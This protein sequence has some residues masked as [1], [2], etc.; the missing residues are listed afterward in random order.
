[1]DNIRNL[2]QGTDFTFDASAKQITF[3][4]FTPVHANILVI[5]NVTDNILIYTSTLPATKGSLSGQVL[6]MDYDTTGMDDADK[7]QLRYY[8]PAYV[9]PVS[10]STLATQ[11][12][13]AALLAKVIAAPSTEAKQ[14]IIITALAS[15]LTELQL[16]ADLTET[17]PVSVQSLPSGLA[18]SANQA[19]EILELTNIISLL[20]GTLAVNTGLSQPLTDAQLRAAAV[21]VTANAGTNLNTSALALEATLQSV[22]TAVEILDN[23]ISANRGLV[24]EDNSAAILAKLSA[25]PSTG[26]KQDT[27]NTALAAIQTAVQIL[28]NAISGS[29]MQ[30]DVLTLPALPA[31]TNNIGD[32]D[33]L[34]LPALPAGTNNIGDVDVLTLPALPAGTNNIG[35]VDVLTLPA[36]PTGSNVIGKINHAAAVGDGATPYKLT[37]AASTNAT[38]VKGS[39]AKLYGIQVY[40]NN[41]AVRYLKI[42]NKASAPTVGTD[43]PIKVIHIPGNT[44]GAGSN[45]PIPSVGISLATGLAFAITT[46]IADSDTGAVALN[47]ITVNL[48]YI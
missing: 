27:A 19:T 5:S 37:S 32:V 9:V 17:Q 10:S 48:D 46:G 36:I 45:V 7:I 24:T 4:G 42:Y 29:E 6:T 43:T 31:G 44:A 15:L 34:S 47:E 8:D 22:K 16:K 20:S 13:L 2:I 33:V 35:D 23:F 11:T 3:I 40:N 12:T 28:D 30:V 26:A 39:A 25:D 38:S 41:A 18:T 21:P 1:M 14:D